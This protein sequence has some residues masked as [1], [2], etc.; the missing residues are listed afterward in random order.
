MTL[1]GIDISKYQAGI[2]LEVVPADIVIVGTSDGNYI[3]PLADAQVQAAKKAGKLVGVYHYFRNDPLK[4]ARFW[5]KHTE[6]YQDGKTVFFLDAET[7]HVNLPQLCLQFIAEFKKIT[8]IRPVIYTYHHLLKARNWQPCVDNNEGLWGA[9][10]PLGDQR[11]DGYKA[12]SREAAPYWGDKMM[13]WQFTSAGYLNGWNGGLDLNE[14]YVDTKGWYAYAAKNNTPVVAP[15]K[16][17]TKPVVKPAPVKPTPK[18]VPAKVTQVTVQPGDSL[19]AIGARHS[20]SWTEIARL[21]KLSSPY[22]IHPGQKLNLP[23]GSKPAPANVSVVTVENGDSLSSIGVQ[24]K[25]RWQDI[26]RVNKIAAP[27]TIYPGQK[28]TLP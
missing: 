5:A 12:P 6:G 28:L 15:T 25:V 17:V 16:P 21:N 7:D 19:S 11:I 14:F 27:Y 2:N 23:G 9:W 1:N 4:E 13:G 26:A 10:Y 20:V 3:N 22:T 18:P 8:G 24:F